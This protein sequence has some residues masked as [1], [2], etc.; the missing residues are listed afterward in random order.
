MRES[1]GSHW[2]LAVIRILL[3]VLATTFSLTACAEPAGGPE[4]S[5]AAPASL[6]AGASG[7]AKPAAGTAEARAVAAI[8]K[9]NPD[10]KV[11]HVSA[12]PLPGFTQAIAAGQVIYVSNDGRYLVL[13]GTGGAVLDL[14][15]SRNLS[16]EAMGA[17]R[18]E[19][20]SKIPDSERV[21]FAPANPVHTVT[22]FTDVECGYCRRMH[23]EIDQYN[24]QGIAIE[25]LAFPRM[26]PGSENFENMVK[27]WCS[28]DRRE[29][30]TRAKATGR[31]TGSAGCKN[32]VRQQYD[33][34]QRA[35]LTGTPMILSEEGVQLGGYVPPAKLREALD[36]LAG[37]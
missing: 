11:E 24:A 5:G 25:Y 30:L 10:V 28:G 18:V 31:V 7:A 1:A 36:Q 20:L 22:V 29:A 26:G 15:R 3:A 6:A 8:A 14:E 2:V 4:A 35:G 17:M 32:T 16:E 13:A 34:G 23:E 21:I 27:V 33:I 37:G 19:L 9:L 12:S